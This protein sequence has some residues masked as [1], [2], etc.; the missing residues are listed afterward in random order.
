M[1]KYKQKQMT[2]VDIAGMKCPCCNSFHG[3]TKPK[4]NR[5][6]RAKLKNEDIRNVKGME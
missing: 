5:I 4:L 6:A 3:K 2:Q 1:D